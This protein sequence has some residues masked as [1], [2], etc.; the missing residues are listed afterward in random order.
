MPGEWKSGGGTEGKH[1]SFLTLEQICE[2]KR[3]SVVGGK[4]EIKA[5]WGK[6]SGESWEEMKT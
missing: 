6:C 4:G 1:P 2:Q 3:P 5:L